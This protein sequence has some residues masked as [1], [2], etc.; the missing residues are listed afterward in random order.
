[1]KKTRI[2]KT[3]KLSA[4][5]KAQVPVGSYIKDDK[6]AKQ[7]IQTALQEGCLLRIRTKA[8][9]NRTALSDEEVGGLNASFLGG[10]KALL[11]K[12]AVKDVK[13]IRRQALRWARENCL[14][15][16]DYGVYFIP[17]SK[18]E[19][20][21][22]FLDDCIARQKVAVQE[23]CSEYLELKETMRKEV[24]KANKLN[25][26]NIKFD[27]S[28]YPTVDELSK[29]FSISFQFFMVSVPDG[30]SILDT[31]QIKQE[32]AKLED[33][34][35]EA[36]EVGILWVRVKFVEIVEHL[37]KVLQSG[38][39]FKNASVINLHEF[40]N[41]FENLNVWNDNDLKA[42]VA[43]ARKELGTTD[44]QD[45]REDAKFAKTVENKMQGILEQV[46]KLGDERLKRAVKF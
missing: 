3:K 40:I 25:G 7:I 31:R 23:L 16:I 35:K 18:V 39:K 30:N 21:V 17:R 29:K 27:E 33:T 37:R 38:G 12:G 43:K 44:A 8:W 20:A 45:L 24:T 9:G 4:S 32:Q 42:I 2:K 10:T 22:E 1:M 26:T 41:Q 36:A 14:P 6:A 5:N 15:W 19:K 13:A 34:I 11:P 46:N 28:R